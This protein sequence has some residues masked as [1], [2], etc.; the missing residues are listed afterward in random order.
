MLSPDQEK[1]IK[2]S[3]LASIIVLNKFVVE[4]P[5]ESLTSPEDQRV[6]HEINNMYTQ[7]I[8]FLGQLEANSAVEA[9]KKA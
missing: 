1:A 2:D 3:T 5:L 8:N 6:W 9:S 7:Q 4:N